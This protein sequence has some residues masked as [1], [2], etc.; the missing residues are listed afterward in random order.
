MLARACY[1][2]N[3]AMLE[4][5]ETAIKELT[6]YFKDKEISPIRVYLSAG[7]CGGPYLALGLDDPADDD[8]VKEEGPFTFC[9][10]TELLNKAGDISVDFNGMGFAVT[11]ENSF[12][13]GGCANCAAGC[14]GG[15]D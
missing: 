6:E 1:L 7:G 11:S 8:T 13:G 4:V 15:D 12:G 9:I 10:N 2:E 14:H 3:P 5:K